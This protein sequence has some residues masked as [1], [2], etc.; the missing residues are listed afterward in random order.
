MSSS[1]H[2]YLHYTPGMSPTSGVC[3]SEALGVF[4]FEDLTERGFYLFLTL[5]K[6]QGFFSGKTFILSSTSG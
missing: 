4:K 5:R 1:P 2:P 3:V 6:T